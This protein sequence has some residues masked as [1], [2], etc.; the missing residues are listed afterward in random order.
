MDLPGQRAEQD[1]EQVGHDGRH[2]AEQQFG[3]ARGVPPERDD[4]QAA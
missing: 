4:G 3:P 1:E 2:H